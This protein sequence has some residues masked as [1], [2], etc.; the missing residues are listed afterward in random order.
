MF[1]KCT[2][3]GGISPLLAKYYPHTQW[4]FPGGQL[5]TEWIQAH[6][7]DNFSADGPMHFELAFEENKEKVMIEIVNPDWVCRVEK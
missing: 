7:H 5:L 3:C 1:L 4:Y 6:H 2:K